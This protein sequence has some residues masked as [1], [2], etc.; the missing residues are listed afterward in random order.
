[1]APNQS[2]PTPQLLDFARAAAPALRR[3]IENAGVGT[4]AGE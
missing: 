3:M 4:V 1:M 2:E